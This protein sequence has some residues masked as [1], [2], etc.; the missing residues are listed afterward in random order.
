MSDFF[1][2]N[3]EELESSSDSKYD[4][5]AP[6]AARMRPRKLNEYIG[7]DHILGE[8]K[9]LSRAIEADRFASLIFY[10]PPGIGK[11]SLAK[12]ISNHSKSRFLNLSGVE[13]N[14][15]EIRKSVES[16]ESLNRLHQSTTTLFVDEIHRFNKA[17]QD[18]LL[19]HI[20]RGTVR[21]IGATTHNPFFYVNSPLVSRSQVFELKPLEEKDL[22]NLIRV[23]LNDKDRGLGH[24]NIEITDEAIELI[25]TKSDGDARKCLNALE[26][27]IMTTTPDKDNV[28]R[29]NLGVAEES[30]QQKTI[31]YDGD[32]DAHYDTISAFIKSMRGSDP[33]ATLYWLAKML[34]AGEDPRF[35]VRRIVIAAS[36]DI[37]LADS[38]ALRVAI[39][40]QQAV[41]FIGMP[42]AQITLAHAA[43]Y[44][45]TA[46]KSNRAYSGLM[47]AKTDISEVER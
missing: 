35:I 11:T 20:E 4:H 46:P 9:L 19:P 6:L 44:L 12:V 43:V 34:Y 38:N 41:D 21:F 25:T 33:D 17:Q 30:I 22:S 18:V 37:G 8:G 24:L 28:I 23:A 3:Q 27:G 29:F 45:A 42:E 2:N 16:A 14:V 5:D 13:S 32:G 39:D 47:K 31:V 26:L 15:A 40:A 36:E 7:Q 1:K 10:G